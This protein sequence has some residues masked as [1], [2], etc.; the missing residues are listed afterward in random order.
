MSPWHSK[1]M[2]VDRWKTRCT[3]EEVA[4]SI[5]IFVF[6]CVNVVFVSLGNSLMK[7]SGPTAGAVMILHVLVFCL[8]PL[9]TV[10]R[11]TCTR[12]DGTFICGAMRHA[13]PALD[14]QLHRFQVGLLL[15]E[16]RQAHPVIPLT[17]AHLGASLYVPQSEQ[18]TAGGAQ[19]HLPA[20]C[21]GLLDPIDF[22]GY[23]Q[24]SAFPTRRCF[25]S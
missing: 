15:R 24:T 12:F 1:E 2:L 21:G 13:A 9:L 10:L 8:T 11:R 23:M 6:P 16:A 19:Q 18:T 4:C 22:T 5:I 20:W 25:H 3:A 17:I 14:S 7:R